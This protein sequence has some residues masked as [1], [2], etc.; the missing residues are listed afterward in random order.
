MEGTGR[1]E[2][3]LRMVSKVSVGGAEKSGDGLRMVSR[4]SVG[5]TGLW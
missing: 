4:I 2:D 1:S 3:G 5:G